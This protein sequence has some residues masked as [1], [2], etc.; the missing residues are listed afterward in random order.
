M[1]HKINVLLTI[2]A[3]T[4]FDMVS[5]PTLSTIN[6]VFAYNP[7]ADNPIFANIKGLDNKIFDGVSAVDP[8]SGSGDTGSNSGSGSGD[9]GSNSGSGSGDTSSGGATC[10]SSGKS[11][12]HWYCEGT[13]H[14][15]LKGEQKCLLFGGRSK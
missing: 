2:I 12:F 11:T 14:H 6:T 13:H 5:A 1:H 10:G 3:I 8:E 15:C 4:A 9:T 7:F